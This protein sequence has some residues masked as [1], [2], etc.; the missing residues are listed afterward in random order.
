MGQL[1]GWKGLM[2]MPQCRKDVDKG[3][4]RGLVLPEVVECGVGHGGGVISWGALSRKKQKSHDLKRL[5]TLLD[6]TR[7]RATVP[8][9]EHEA[10]VNTIVPGTRVLV[11]FMTSRNTEWYRSNK[12]YI[13]PGL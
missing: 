3:R 11:E 7:S 6:T 13:I 9:R 10:E 2:I 8:R 1:L 5:E 4:R 12:K